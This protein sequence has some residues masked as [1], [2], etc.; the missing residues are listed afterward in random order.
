MT[1]TSTCPICLENYTEFHTT[2]RIIKSCGHT[3]CSSCIDQIFLAN[4]RDNCP[5]DNQALD[6]I[7][8]ALEQF[9]K[10]FS[11][12]SILKTLPN[13][14]TE[15]IKGITEKLSPYFDIESYIDGLEIMWK[16]E[17]YTNPEK[18]TESLTILRSIA[19]EPNL[20][21]KIIGIHYTANVQIEE[22]LFLLTKFNHI[23][24][25]A[26][27]F[28]RFP[29]KL[30][31]ALD[32]LIVFT[33]LIDFKIRCTKTLLNYLPTLPASL[34][35][36]LEMLNLEFSM[37][38]IAHI[39]AFV[40]SLLLYKKLKD[41][42]ID[43]SNNLTLQ[44]SELT[45]FISSLQ[46]LDGLQHLELNFENIKIITTQLTNR[47]S[48][49]MMTLPRLHRVVLN[50]SGNKALKNL[51]PDNYSASIQI[52]PAVKEIRIITR[53]CG[54]A[55]ESTIFHR[56]QVQPEEGRSRTNIPLSRQASR[57]NPDLEGGVRIGGAGEEERRGPNWAKV[58]KVIL[59]ILFF[60]L[61]PF[62]FFYKWL[63]SDDM[64]V[65][66]CMR[67]LTNLIPCL[68]IIIPII[69]VLLIMI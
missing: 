8:C 27:D 5:L 1:S 50:F 47:L 41:L 58:F 43:L 68:I 57:V 28:T 60:P 56:E 6:F 61:L 17:I 4:K 69:I 49:I 52:N 25:L 59:M 42:K 13:S 45:S 9:P 15:D 18:Y 66:R 38:Q 39:S 23:F 22:S 26:L 64:R 65:Q 16:E 3:L 32:S 33:E 2:P 37:N 20:G 51:N 30:Q 10:N 7:P 31:L 12:I 24:I 21:Q 35:A 46:S 29:D 44:V 62:Y 55:Q 34:A 11:L 53:N 48:N 19:D 67:A 63:T 36:K 40:T 14:S 54:M